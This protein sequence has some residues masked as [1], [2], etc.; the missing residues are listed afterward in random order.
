MSLGMI[1][2]DQLIKYKDKEVVV[3]LL[4]TYNPDPKRFNQALRSAL[5][6]CHRV[7]IID[8]NSSNYL[9]IL[10]SVRLI[11]ERGKV[12]VV[13]NTMNLGLAAALNLGK[14]LAMQRFSPDWILLLDQDT[15][16]S[17]H[18]AF[19]L[20]SKLRFAGNPSNVGVMGALNRETKLNGTFSKLI[21]LLFL[22]SLTIRKKGT[23]RLMEP[24]FI[25]ISGSMIKSI[26][27]MT[28]S[29]REEFFLDWVDYDFCTKVKEA[30]FRVL[31]LNA[32]LASHSLGMIKH[33]G[34]LEVLYEPSFRYYLIVR[35]A[36]ILFREGK[37]SLVRLLY[38]TVR[39]FMPLVL[40]EG[41]TAAVKAL[42]LGFK[43]EQ[44][45][46]GYHIAEDTT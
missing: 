41:L 13:R 7:I 34:K 46:A 21:S 1:D 31:Q 38:A 11:D 19:T 33:L 5:A 37:I 3:C 25:I 26:V 10:K 27:A 15:V 43:L 39:W 36:R 24:T 44:F 17:P 20:L 29:F 35:N 8:N 45:P 14:A 22:D 9:D 42:R 40:A 12:V 6:Q 28:I 18:Y 23:L 32:V 30:G 16:L 4:V 2:T